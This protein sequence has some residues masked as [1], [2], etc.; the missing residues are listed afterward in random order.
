MRGPSNSTLSPSSEPALPSPHQP[1]PCGTQ[2]KGTLQGSQ[3]AGGVLCLRPTR[4]F[5]ASPFGLKRRQ[6]SFQNPRNHTTGL[7]ALGGSL[8]V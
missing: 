4:G 6:G 1:L 2:V 7:A 5:L 3:G 8:H